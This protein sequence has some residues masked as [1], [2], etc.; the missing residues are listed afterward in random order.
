M[1]LET[2]KRGDDDSHGLKDSQTVVLRLYE[3][4]GG[5]G[6]AKLKIASH[7]PVH[8][9][10]VTNLLE[11]ELD[12]LNIMRADDTEETAAVL[13]LDFRGFEVKTVKLIIGTKESANDL[14]E[15]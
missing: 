4:Y 6:Q 3:A 11:D 7:V 1:F 2:V 15:E 14:P 8:K 5:H 10:F 12:E 13:K 9:A